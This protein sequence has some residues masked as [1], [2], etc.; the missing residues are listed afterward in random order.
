MIYAGLDVHKRCTQICLEDENGALLERR[1]LTDRHRLWRSSV[2]SRPCES[3]WNQP[4]RVSGWRTAWKAPVTSSSSGIR[5][6]RR[7]TRSEVGE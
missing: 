7:C 3:S 2:A 1:I 4:P 5:I 6:S